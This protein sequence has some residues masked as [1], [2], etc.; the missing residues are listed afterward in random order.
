LDLVAL[1][2]PLPPS[3]R[4]REQRLVSAT[5]IAFRVKSYAG[6]TFTGRAV[7]AFQNNFGQAKRTAPI[8]SVSRFEIHAF[9]K[10]LSDT[11]D[12]P[13][14]RM[15]MRIALDATLQKRALDP[16]A[17]GQRELFT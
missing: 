3:D 6:G 2:A 4:G 9:G 8:L 7:R 15:T 16:V 13:P 14:L 10:Q 11:S 12:A 1:V 17:L 5:N